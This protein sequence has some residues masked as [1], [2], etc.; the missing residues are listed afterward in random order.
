MKKAVEIDLPPLELSAARLEPAYVEQPLH[1]PRERLCLLS[2]CSADFTLPGIQLAVNILLKELEISDDD[3]DRCLE[4]VRCHRHEFGF[5]LVQLR[6][7]RCHSVI[8]VCE[9]PELV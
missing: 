8:A 4:L 2:Q 6:E 3:V 1:E 7:L 9:P 5:Q